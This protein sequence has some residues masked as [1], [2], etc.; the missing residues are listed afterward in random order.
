MAGNAVEPGRTVLSRALAIL[1]SFSE[2]RP[3]QTL[4][5]IVRDTGLAPATV[6]RLL[7]ELVEWGAL[8]RHGRGRYR[9]GLRL[10]QLGALAPRGR[11]LRDVALP[12]LEDLYEATHQVVHLV[13]RDEDQ[14]LYVEKLSAR[15]QVGVVSQ[16]GGRLPL[17]ST[18]PG[19]VLLAY[20]PP[21]VRERLLSGPLARVTPATITDAGR[22]RTVLADIRGTG[23]CLSR[24]EMTMGA[25]SVAAPVFGRPGEVAAAISVV[26]P[27]RTGNLAP[28]VPAV[29]AAALGISRALRDEFPADD[30]VFR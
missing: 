1:D 17:H 27:S 5:M 6:H 11:R 2:R 10:W 4:G 8:E 21:E 7:A 13:V 19:K 12:Y 18:G 9:I 23:Y 14:A 22:L 24:D 26:V 15:P 28:L 3:E 16:V 25:S 29:R 30:E 20:A